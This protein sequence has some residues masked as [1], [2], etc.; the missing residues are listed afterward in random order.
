M[1]VRCLCQIASA[2]AYHAKAAAQHARVASDRTNRACRGTL[3]TKNA[4]GE[5]EAFSKV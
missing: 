4:P 1:L 3:K 2:N 5:P